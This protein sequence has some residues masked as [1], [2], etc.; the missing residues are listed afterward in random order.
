M[1]S[2]EL[3]LIRSLLVDS[4]SIELQGQQSLTKLIDSAVESVRK[5]LL[6]NSDEPHLVLVA[7]SANASMVAA[8]ISAWKRHKLSKA[9]AR[10]QH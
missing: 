7:N 1:N 3:D 6:G 10:R 9:S 5:G 8:A 2:H 4:S